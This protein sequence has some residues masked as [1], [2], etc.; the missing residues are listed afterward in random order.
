MNCSTRWT[1]LS[2]SRL[3]W[4]G[5]FSQIDV[6]A[7]TAP[8]A[9]GAALQAAGDQMLQAVIFHG[10]SLEFSEQFDATTGYAKS[11]EQPALELQLPS[12]GPRQEHHMGGTAT[13]ASVRE[14]HAR[15][16]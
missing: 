14:N 15:R 6:G 4:S 11:A 5:C 3:T 9:A 16:R 12:R 1:A 8:A 13:R 2:W 7:S 10:G